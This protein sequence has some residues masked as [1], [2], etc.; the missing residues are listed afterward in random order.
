MKQIRI[1]TQTKIMKDMTFLMIL[2]YDRIKAFKT[3]ADENGKQTVDSNK[4]Q[5]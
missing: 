2:Q 4:V 3:D 1:K 5:D